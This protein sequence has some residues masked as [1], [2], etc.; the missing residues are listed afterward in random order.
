MGQCE[1][2]T[3]ELDFN[4]IQVDS[5]IKEMGSA[6]VGHEIDQ[7]RADNQAYLEDYRTTLM[8]DK[9]YYKGK[10]VESKK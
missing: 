9:T 4:T 7:L 10:L 8:P 6:G 1:V 2:C 3:N 5:L